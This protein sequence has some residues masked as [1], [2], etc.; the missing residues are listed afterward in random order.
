MK[1]YLWIV[2]SF[3]LLATMVV[4]ALAEERKCVKTVRVYYDF[5]QVI[6]A[7]AEN[8]RSVTKTACYT[9]GVPAVCPVG[10]TGL[11]T[12]DTSGGTSSGGSYTSDQSSG[13][14]SVSVSRPTLINPEE[15]IYP[16]CNSTVCMAES[17]ECT[18]SSVILSNGTYNFSETDL[19]LPAR[20]L[21]ISWK[22]YYRSNRVIE[23]ASGKTFG[24]PADGPLGYGWRTDY[25]AR[26]ENG[27]TYVDGR[28]I[29]THFVQTPVVG[30]YLPNLEEGLVLKKIAGGY[31]L[32]ELGG[33]I[34]RFDAD[35][36][37][38][39]ISDRNGN[40]LMLTYDLE[41]RLEKIIDATG[42]E[43]LTFVYSDTDQRIDQVMDAG[44]RTISY[45][46]DLAGNLRQVTGL[47]RKESVYSRKR[48]RT[49]P[50]MSKVLSTIFR[51][52][53]ITSPT[54]TAASPRKPTIR[55]DGSLPKR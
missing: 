32:E 16:G 39:S 31:E 23:T 2:I 45:S 17:T 1:K 43:A 3:L 25:F 18:G 51:T 19:H 14:S 35:G 26:I 40:Q 44:G 55:T 21:P 30:G 34:R 47:E 24:E 10:T 7:G 27:D 13:G 42:R 53:P 33:L 22:R 41:A 12:A 5:E 6:C 4:P 46:Y 49:R 9:V 15:C 52:A 38:V 8:E 11:V 29:F 37:L 28:G 20:G 54:T 48:D 36:R 50:V